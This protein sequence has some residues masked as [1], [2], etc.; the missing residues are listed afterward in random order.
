MKITRVN[1]KPIT[2]RPRLKAMASITLDDE[3][4]INDIKIVQARNRL[5]AE[6]PKPNAPINNHMEYIVPLNCSVRKVMESVILG[7]YRKKIGA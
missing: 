6:F 7:A 2:D 4:I 5:C 1:I 3:L